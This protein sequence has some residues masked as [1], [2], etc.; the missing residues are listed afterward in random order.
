MEMITQPLKHCIALSFGDFAF[1]FRKREMDNVVMV[2]ILAWQFGAEFQPHLVEQVN[3]LR[4]EARRMRP[5]IK[6]LFLAG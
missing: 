6:N 2:E 5:Q 1:D 4:R 3:F